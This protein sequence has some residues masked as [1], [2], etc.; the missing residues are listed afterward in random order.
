MISM[1]DDEAQARPGVNALGAADAGGVGRN[2]TDGGN[3]VES[4]TA[5]TRRTKVQ[6]A[7]EV[8]R[9]Q[10]VERGNIWAA[11]E[12]VLRNKGAPGPDGLR[13]QDL[14]ACLQAHWPAVKVALLAGSYLPREVRAVDIPKPDG[15]GR[16]LGVP[17]VVDRLIQ[18]ALLQ[19]L[20][21]IFDSN[22]SESSYG[23]RPGRN[24]WQAV[25]TARERGRGG[26]GWV[27]YVRGAQ[28]KDVWQDLDGWIRGKPHECGVP[29]VLL[30]PHG[31]GFAGGYH[32]RFQIH[33]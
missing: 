11:Y 23:F 3:G 29:E 32:R 5:T 15:G 7:T 6:E 9:E 27:S 33:S 17:S 20:Q 2:P 18:Q 14:K 24:A 21:P 4:C 31:A 13:V 8:R 16:T 10:G 28:V 22:F 19:V 12:R 1:N 26:R 25:Q 30:R